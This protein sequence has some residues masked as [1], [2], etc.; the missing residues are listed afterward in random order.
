MGL[1]RRQV[2]IDF[3]VIATD[4]DDWITGYDEKPTLTY[5]VSVGV[6]VLEPLVLDYIPCDRKFDLPDLVRALIG[7]SQRV[8]GYRF[9]GY[10]LDI[11]RQEDYA[12]AI[13]LF[14]TK[15]A[16]FLGPEQ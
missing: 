11:G 15:R 3:G 12:R 4:G 5:E 1:F 14:E 10:W 7:A 9:D 8:V 2:P 6:Y 16:V 13:E